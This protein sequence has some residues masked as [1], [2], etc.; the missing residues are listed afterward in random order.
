M[1]CHGHLDK[2]PLAAGADF[3]L[4]HRGHFGP[5]LFVLRDRP[6]GCPLAAMKFLHHVVCGPLEGMDA[7]HGSYISHLLLVRFF[8]FAAPRGGANPLLDRA[9]HGH[10]FAV[11]RHHQDRTLFLRRRGCRVSAKGLGMLGDP[12]AHHFGRPLAGAQAQQHPQRLT[13][14]VERILHAQSLQPVLQ[15]VGKLSRQHSQRFIQRRP[16]D[17]LPLPPGIDEP[18]NHQFAEDRQV[19]SRARLCQPLHLV[20]VVRQGLPGIAV[21]CAATC[22]S[23]KVR[24]TSSSCE[25]NSRSNSSIRNG[26]R[27]TS[28]TSWHSAAN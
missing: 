11:G 5:D 26:F 28:R 15:H 16:F 18:P 22:A 20:P 23:N 12:L 13:G 6:V 21:P 9:P 27:P 14:F 1:R 7:I 4:G 17:F 25:N 3:S 24:P 10:A 19:S 2:Q 8:P